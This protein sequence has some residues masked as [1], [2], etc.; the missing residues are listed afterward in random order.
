[1]AT[2][3][4]TNQTKI[5]NTKTGG[6]LPH[7]LSTI[8]ISIFTTM[9]LVVVPIDRKYVYPLSGQNKLLHYSSIEES[10]MSTLCGFVLIHA[11][12]HWIDAAKRDPV[13]RINFSC[14][15]YPL[16]ASCLVLWV[17]TCLM[18]PV[19]GVVEGR[20]HSAVTSRSRPQTRIKTVDSTLPGWKMKTKLNVSV[21][22]KVEP[23]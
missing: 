15:V 9:T 8:H 3:K 20:G 11:W 4:F 2:V 18:A 12:T 17:L 6:T 1:M 14:Y 19:V 16:C 23:L 13:I 10:R 5:V 22:S 21:F 7:S